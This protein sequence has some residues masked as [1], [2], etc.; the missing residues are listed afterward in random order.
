MKI[1]RNAAWHFTSLGGVEE[2]RAKLLA[3]SHTEVATPEN[4]DRANIG[5][6]LA[7][8]R[9]VLGRAALR[10]VPLDGLPWAL[11]VDAGRWRR[12]LL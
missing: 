4:I 1:E 8:G 7:E 3:F 2:I 11:Q 12:Y 5:K 9:T 6:A 10:R